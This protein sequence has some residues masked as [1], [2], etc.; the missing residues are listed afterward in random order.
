MSNN[1]SLDQIMN[2]FTKQK[3]D[4]E[5]QME[6]FVQLQNEIEKLSKKSPRSAQDIEKLNNLQQLEENQDFIEL[7]ENAMNTIQ[8]LEVQFSQLSR[9]FD[10]KPIAKTSPKKTT[11]EEL[12]AQPQKKK[13]TH[14]FA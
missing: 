9:M 3:E 12:K 5:K 2:N 6:K 14:K 11:S 10:Q 1:D 8:Q 4:L 13:G 7:R